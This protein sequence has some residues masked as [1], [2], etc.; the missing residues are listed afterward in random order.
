MS[1]PN[2]EVSLI[3]QIELGDRVAAAL[4]QEQTHAYFIE[5]LGDLA[6]RAA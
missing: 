6:I 4:E 5:D 3:E 1:M 2:R